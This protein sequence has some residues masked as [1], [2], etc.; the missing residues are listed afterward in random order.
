MLTPRIRATIKRTT[1][2]KK[3]IFAIEAAP[4]AISVNPKMD[5]IIAIT[6]N[7]SDHFSM[8]L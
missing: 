3:I 1:N 6:R 8:L 5:A 2:T 7:I 4:A